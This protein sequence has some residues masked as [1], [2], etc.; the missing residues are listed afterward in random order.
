MFDMV[1]TSVR[2]FVDR[3]V[4]PREDEIEETDSI[5]DFL[6]DEA[7]KMGLFGYALPEAY[8]GLGFDMVEEVRLCFELGRT[9]PAFRSQFGTN[10]GIAGQTIANYGTEEQK[11]D[12]L[13]KLASGEAVGC[14]ALSEAEA[15]S[16]PSGMRTRAR[17]DGDEYVI[18]GS[19]RFITNAELSTVYVLFARTDPDAKGTKGISAFLVDSGLDGITLGPHDKKMGQQGAWTSEIFFDDVRVPAAALIGGEEETGFRA[20]MKSLAKGRLTIAAC[21]VGLAERI[22]EE[23]TAYALENRQGG[24]RI[25]DYQ[26]VQALLA[27]S[28]TEARAGRA[29][30]LETARA[31]EDGSDQ[32]QGPAC[33]KLFCSQMVNRVADRGVQVLG[34]MGYMRTVP[35]ERFYRDARLYRIY[36]GTDEIQKLVIARQMLAAQGAKVAA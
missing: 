36:E 9:A 35:I 14:F 4:I 23:A 34:G 18:N 10:N 13:P 3:E 19:K 30:A 29:M 32:R 11:A 5:P 33:A 27:E 1:I 22:I 2:E 17:R 8:G 16:D 7:V 31:Y 15:G 28:E 21:C 26:L 12:Y 20:A 25:G 6:R 24:T